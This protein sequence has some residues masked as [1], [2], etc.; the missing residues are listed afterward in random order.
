MRVA[1]IEG[2]TIIGESLLL[3]PACRAPDALI[4]DPMKKNRMTCQNCKTFW[5]FKNIRVEMDQ[6][7][8]MPFSLIGK[9]GTQRAS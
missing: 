3:C 5:K 9:D 1:I 4:P 8:F 7:D 6:V 2:N